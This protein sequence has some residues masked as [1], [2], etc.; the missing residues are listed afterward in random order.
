MKVGKTHATHLSNKIV[1]P[2]FD[3][4]DENV[5]LSGDT[6][7]NTTQSS[8][9]KTAGCGNSNTFSLGQRFK[10]FAQVPLLFKMLC[11]RFNSFIESFF[12]ANDYIM[13]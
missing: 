13:L 10:L 6:S 12:P 8:T 11:N 5:N 3:K 1:D 9:S 4:C 2:W 7:F